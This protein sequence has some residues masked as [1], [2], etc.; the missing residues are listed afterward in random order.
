MVVEER[1]G[2]YHGQDYSKLRAQCW[3]QDRLFQDPEFPADQRSIGFHTTLQ[4]KRPKE[5]VDNPKFM[6]HADRFSVVQGELGDCWFVSAMSAITLNPGLLRRVVPNDQDFTTTKYA[7]IFHFRLWQGGEWVDVVVDDRLPVTADN[8]LCFSHSANHAEFWSAL[9]EKAYAK[10]HGSYGALNAGK[11][12]EATEDLTGGVT[13]RFLLQR[14]TP[15]HNLYSIIEQA[16]H[17]GS[18]ITCNSQGQVE[19]R[20]CGLVAGHG[21]CV[22]GV[23]LCK[24]NT[25]WLTHVQ[26]LRLRNPWGDGH[27]WRG[28]WSDD[29]EEWRLVP[30]EDKLRLRLQAA[31][32]GEFWMTFQ[33]FKENFEEVYITSLNPHTLNKEALEHLYTLADVVT[34]VL[35]HP[36]EKRQQQQDKLTRRKLWEV[37]KYDGSWVRKVTAG[38]APNDLR[39]FSSNPQYLLHLK[40]A[41]DEAMEGGTCTVVISLTQKHRRVN[42]LPLLQVAVSVYQMEDG[43]AVTTPLHVSW[44]RLNRPLLLTKFVRTRTVTR[45]LHLPPGRYI[46][47]PCTHSPDQEGDFL[48]RVFCQKSATMKEHD[49]SP[50]LVDT[51]LEMGDK[52]DSRSTREESSS[53]CIQKDDFLAAAGEDGRMTAAILQNILNFLFSGELEFSLDLTRSLLAMMD[54]NFSGN[55]DF[56]EFDTL[57]CC[58]RRWMIDFK[59]TVVM[60]WILLQYASPSGFKMHSTAE[61]QSSLTIVLA[62]IFC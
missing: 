38:G 53:S 2:V 30:K 29:S 19:E 32:D 44:F 9:L 22:T 5:L 46:I 36:E 26:L 10:L 54:R 56:Y 14:E 4:W 40:E 51:H 28:A 31:D 8:Q 43:E 7:G 60:E 17:R 62:H 55:V 59:N 13:E 35:H 42:N 41:D 58:L 49:E 20:L 37:V 11:C 57:V 1:L 12:Y 39:L 6:D 25:P 3:V 18:L 33:A 16:S 61:T 27:E 47:I 48:L 50:M 15:P 52:V 21:Y 34:H 23:K 45:R 24:V